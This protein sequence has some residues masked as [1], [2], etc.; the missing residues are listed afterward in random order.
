MKRFFAVIVLIY[1]ALLVTVL[2]GAQMAPI[3]TGE[4]GQTFSGRPN[5]GMASGVM[6]GGV[7]TQGRPVRGMAGGS[8]RKSLAATATPT[9][10]PSQTP[11]ATPT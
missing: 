2:V 1:A 7:D 6:G 10:V 5:G 9:P 4:N 3:A 11:T 8:G